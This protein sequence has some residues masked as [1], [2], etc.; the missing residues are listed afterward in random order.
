MENNTISQAQEEIGGI[1]IDS[2]NNIY[3]TG[4]AV[5]GLNGVNGII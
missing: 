2:I 4:Y 5:L 3:V 1:D